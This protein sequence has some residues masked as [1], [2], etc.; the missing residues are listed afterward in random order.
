MSFLSDNH[1]EGEQGRIHVTT[2]SE[3]ECQVCDCERK[4][5][6]R[7]QLMALIVENEYKLKM[8]K[9]CAIEM[10]I[11]M[12]QGNHGHHPDCDG[13]CHERDDDE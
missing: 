13:H 9:F 10:F 8:C 11:S 2:V 6:P 4:N 12:R 1:P 5:I 7:E 3:E